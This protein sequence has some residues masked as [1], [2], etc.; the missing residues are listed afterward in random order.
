M[1]CR[2]I[3]HSSR[4][5]YSVSLN[6]FVLIT[7][8]AICFCSEI[9][10]DDQMSLH[11]KALGIQNIA[12]FAFLSPPPALNLVKS[13]Q[14][15]FALRIIDKQGQLTKVVGLSTIKITWGSP[16]LRCYLTV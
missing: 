7:F 15:L 4:G 6:P 9:Q 14:E 8:T 3:Q 1:Y 11:L 2:G 12:R 10:R 16:N 5:D 13:V